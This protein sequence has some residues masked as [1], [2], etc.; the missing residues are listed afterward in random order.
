M[1]HVDGVIASSAGPL[2]LANAH[3]KKLLGLYR[4][5]AGYIN[6]WGPIGHK[7]SVISHKKGVKHIAVNQVAGAVTDW[8]I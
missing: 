7:A 5:N 1:K 6:R 3:N 2:H 4:N 8:I